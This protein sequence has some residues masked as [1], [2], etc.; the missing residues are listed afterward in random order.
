MSPPSDTSTPVAVSFAIRRAA[1]SAANALPV[2]PRS[3][4][5]PRGTRIVQRAPS[6]T[7]FRQVGVLHIRTTRCR[8]SSLAISAKSQS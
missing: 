4:S 8:R 7:I 3:S 2:A 6:R 1:R 5:T